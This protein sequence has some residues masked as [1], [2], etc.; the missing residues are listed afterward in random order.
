MAMF[1]V[2]VYTTQNSTYRKAMED[3]HTWKTNYMRHSNDGYFAVFDGHGSHRTASWAAD[4][5]HQLIEK[6]ILKY[7]SSR[8]PDQILADSFSQA[9]VLLAKCKKSHKNIIAVENEDH[10]DSGTT[11][12]VAYIHYDKDTHES[13]LYTANV[14]DSRIVLGTDS[15]GAYRLSKDHKAC[16]PSEQNRIRQCGGIIYNNRVFAVLS[17]TRALGDHQLKDYVIAKPFTAET[18][19]EV[20]D[21]CLIIA[22]DGLWDV[23]DDKSAVAMIKDIDDCDD[24]AKLLVEYALKRGSMD[25]IT[26][27]VVRWSLKQTGDPTTIQRHSNRGVR[28]RRISVHRNDPLKIYQRPPSPGIFPSIWSE[29][30][31]KNS[32]SELEDDLNDIS[33][34]LDPLPGIDPVTNEIKRLSLGTEQYRY[35]VKRKEIPL[36]LNDSYESDAVFEE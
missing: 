34:S 19:L 8:S 32:D 29:N 15:G 31:P 1:R 2:G 4:N 9:D 33:P 24:A 36:D 14:G 16:D 25:N 23:C 12:A 17:I 21:N 22:C 35:G 7:G 13:H 11:A 26:C 28:K 18:I 30:T 27:M 6:N 5:L 3:R 20:G 10:Q